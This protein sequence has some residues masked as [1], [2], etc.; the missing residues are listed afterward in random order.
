MG[1]DD[2]PSDKAFSSY[3]INNLVEHCPTLHHQIEGFWKTESFGVTHDYA[4]PISVEDQR[5]EKM[6]EE[7]TTLVDGRYQVPMLWKTT[8]AVLP[9][10]FPVAQRRFDLLSRRFARDEEYAQL[11][12]ETLIVR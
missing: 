4:E 5:A 3:A 9:N 1:V 11:Y 8:E 6:L 12:H 10:N 2:T 7:G